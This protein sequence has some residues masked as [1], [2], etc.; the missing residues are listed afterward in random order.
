MRTDIIQNTEYKVG[1]VFQCGLIKLRCEESR[2][3]G[4]CCEGCFFH[5][6]CFKETTRN[7]AGPCARTQRKDK[8]DVIFVKVEE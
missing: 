4:S 1:E 2:I 5:F 8:T 7:I 6:Y 3:I